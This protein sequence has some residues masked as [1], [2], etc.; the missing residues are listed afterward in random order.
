MKQFKDETVPGKLNRMIEFLEKWDKNITIIP[1]DKKYLIEIKS[2]IENQ[3][4]ELEEVKAE[5]EKYEGIIKRILIY[6]DYID[7]DI[8]KTCTIYDVNGIDIV[9]LIKEG[10]K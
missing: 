6:L 2:L 9:K 4:K 10:L 5:K 1:E 8:L 3:Q 7:D